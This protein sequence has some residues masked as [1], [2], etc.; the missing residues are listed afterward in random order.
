[1]QVSTITKSFQTS[2]ILFSDPD[3]VGNEDLCASER[4]NG[5]GDIATVELT[6]TLDFSQ[7]YKVKP[8]CDYA[9]KN[10]DPS[11][12]QDVSLYC[13]FCSL[14]YFFHLDHAT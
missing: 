12:D 4:W 11:S 3:Y 2:Q 13:F 1:M 5:E 14:T 6:N 10:S 8:A 7:I 9:L